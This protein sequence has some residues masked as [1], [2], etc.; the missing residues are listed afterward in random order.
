MGRR[1]LSW[2]IAG[3]AL[4]RA[5]RL[6][7]LVLRLDRVARGLPLG[8]APLEELVE[9]A[10]VHEVRAA[11]DRDRL[12]GEELALVGHEEGGEVLKLGHFP[13]AVHRVHR[14]RLVAEVAARREALAGALG[15]KD[16][17]R[18]RV[19]AYAVAS[20][21]DRERLGHD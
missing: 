21:L 7:L 3:S 14:D 4:G 9:R 13:G 10:A 16:P 18:D 15:R 11:V 17:R 1:M 19:E 12:A 2:F 5:L 20:P 8:V 6:V